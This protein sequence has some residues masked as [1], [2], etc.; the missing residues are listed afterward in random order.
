MEKVGEALLSFFY[1]CSEPSLL[2]VGSDEEST[3]S[4]NG[5]LN[6]RPIQHDWDGT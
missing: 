1:Q 5:V 6:L 2:S 4:A 3:Q